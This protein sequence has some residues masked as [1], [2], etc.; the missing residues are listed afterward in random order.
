MKID[1]LLG[2]VLIY[3]LKHHHLDVFIK[4]TGPAKGTRNHYAQLYL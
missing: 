1:N 2:A 4:Q 3:R